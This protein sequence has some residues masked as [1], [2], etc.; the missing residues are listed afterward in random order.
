MENIIKNI[1]CQLKII[2]EVM[3][4]L[5]NGFFILSLALL[6]IDCK[7]SFIFYLIFICCF[8]GIYLPTK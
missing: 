5:I 2:H 6:K 7:S 4:A 1:G 3:K 8:L